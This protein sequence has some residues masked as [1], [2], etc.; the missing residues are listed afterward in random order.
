LTVEEAT[1][2]PEEVPTVEEITK[3]IVEEYG[4]YADEFIQDHRVECKSCRSKD[5]HLPHEDVVRC[6]HQSIHAKNALEQA[7]H[8]TKRAQIRARVAVREGKQ[9]KVLRDGLDALHVADDNLKMLIL[10]SSLTAAIE[11]PKKIRMPILTMGKSQHGKS[12]V[13]EVMEHLLPKDRWVPVDSLSAK[14]LLY[15]AK[16]N[17]RVLANK[18]LYIDELGDLND[19]T[20]ALL[21]ALTTYQ[22]DRMTHETVLHQKYTMLVLEGL[23]VLH[24][25][26]AEV[27]MDPATKEQA[28]N[29]W[30]LANVDETE[31]TTKKVLDYQTQEDLM[32]PHRSTKV[33]AIEAAREVV[34]LLMERSDF[35][36]RVPFSGLIDFTGYSNARINRQKFMDLVRAFTF[37]HWPTRPSWVDGD[38]EVF[39]STLEDYRM[40]M[41]V[42]ADIQRYLFE[43]VDEQAFEVARRMKF[44]SHIRTSAIAKACDGVMSDSTVR[45]RL[46]TMHEAGLVGKVENVQRRTYDDDGQL[47]RVWTE[48]EWFLAT[49]PLVIYGDRGCQ[50]LDIKGVLSRLF[51]EIDKT[52]SEI[53]GRLLF[54][55]VNIYNII[56]EYDKASYHNSGVIDTNRLETAATTLGTHCMCLLPENPDKTVIDLNTPST[57][58]H[59]LATVLSNDP[60]QW[61]GVHFIVEPGRLVTG[62]WE[63]PDKT[64][65]DAFD[66]GTPLDPPEEPEVAS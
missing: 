49:D 48:T 25:N 7:W 12:H 6:I 64:V 47:D 14:A 36:V 66:D 1:S 29:R 18:V 42:W 35:D 34:R 41:D 19:E 8:I 17:P 28:F 9:V 23:P 31:E 56:Y 59:G 61:P 40:A 33:E 38:R 4:E 39:F 37:L 55:Y 15:K 20:L 22:R 10:V 24:T 3:A 46:K 50:S 44:G 2:T 63:D 62:G 43:G 51:T 45:R 52:V 53:D 13:E 57:N 21:K 5:G 65:L 16:D 27:D 26:A 11:T 30:F 60:F 58:F 54:V 32:G